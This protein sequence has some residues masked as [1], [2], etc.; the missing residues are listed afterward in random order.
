MNFCSCLLWNGI[1]DIHLFHQFDIACRDLFPA[2]HCG[3]AMTADFLHFGHSGR[4]HLL[5][6]A[7]SV[8]FLQTPA[9]RMIGIALHM[10]RHLKKLF[11]GKPRRRRHM[12]HLKDPF[13]QGPCLVAHHILCL[14]ER[15]KIIRTF[16]QHPL[17]RCAA[18]S[19]K[20]TE[21]NRDHQ[22]TRAADNQCRERTNHPL[23]PLCRIAKHQIH[24]RRHDGERE[25]TDAHC[26]RIILC[27]PGDKILGF[28]FFHAGIFY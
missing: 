28:G 17:G 12:R 2:D 10:C 22:C 13:C 19:A 25:C 6:C 15:L 8:G 4:L 9:D 16:H 1:R 27:K 3:H 5:S 23:G 24:Q 20:K 14:C 18:N 7:I 11:L 21:R 26:G